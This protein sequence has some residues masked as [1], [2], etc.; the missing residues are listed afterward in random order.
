MARNQVQKVIFEN[1]KKITPIYKSIT[2][3]NFLRDAP[4]WQSLVERWIERTSSS[5]SGSNNASNYD[6]SHD[7][8]D[9]DLWDL[10]TSKMM[11]SVRTKTS[12]AT[13]VVCWD[14]GIQPVQFKCTYMVIFNCPVETSLF[15]VP[16]GNRANE[17]TRGALREKIIWNNSSA[18]LVGMFFISVVCTEKGVGRG[19][20][21]NLS[22]EYGIEMVK[23]TVKSHQCEQT[24]SLETC[25]VC[26]SRRWGSRRWRLRWSRPSPPCESWSRW[27]RGSW[28]PRW[29]VMTKEIKLTIIDT[30]CAWLKWD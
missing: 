4:L 16:K 17:P 7:D 24:L 8:I 15:S 19:A 29:Q 23:D 6:R 28:L 25:P 22:A 11:A 10:C 26:K 12:R 18:W 13:Q 30:F 3:S 9:D 5:T 14:V 27:P 2:W 21:K 1:L 20:V